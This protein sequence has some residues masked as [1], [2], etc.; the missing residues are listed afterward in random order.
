MPVLP[1]ASLA[2]TLLAI[3]LPSLAAEPL[4]VVNLQRC[5]DLLN[6]QRQDI[7]LR[8]RGLQA[9]AVRGL[10]AGDALPDSAVQ[11]DEQ[12]LRLQLD[13]KRYKSAP[14]WLEQQGAASNPVWLSLNSSHVVPAKPDEVAKKMDGLT[15]YT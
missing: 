4:R 9:G 1:L 5:G 11:H 7:C 13:P 14:V 10:L 6:N 15:T 3:A 8:T 2:L 12:G